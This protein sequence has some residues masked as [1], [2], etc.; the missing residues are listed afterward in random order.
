MGPQTKT[1]IIALGNSNSFKLMPNL[2][3]HKG[4]HMN[5]F[6]LSLIMLIISTSLH[7][8][9]Y[10][11]LTISSDIESKITQLS[12]V[13]D[14]HDV[15]QKL[16]LLNMQSGEIQSFEISELN[17]GIILEEREGRKIAILKSKDFTPDRGGFLLIDYLHN[18][19]S[20]SRRSLE[21]EDRRTA[22]GPEIAFLGV[23]VSRAH[24]IGNQ[25]FGKVIGIKEINFSQN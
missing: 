15:A 24:I 18:G 12:A 8:K 5:K 7:S 13:F 9:E 11:L 14:E 17:K 21:I 3:N 23:S 2:Y 6:L 19:I 20:G 10:R 16:K 22:D 1:Y 25:L 4:D